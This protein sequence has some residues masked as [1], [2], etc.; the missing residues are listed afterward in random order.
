MRMTGAL[1]K[2]S[3][4]RRHASKTLQRSTGRRMRKSLIPT[5]RST[6]ITATVRCPSYRRGGPCARPRRRNAKNNLRRAAARAAPTAPSPTAGSGNSTSGATSLD[7]LQELF[8]VAGLRSVGVELQVFLEVALRFRLLL[9]LE[10]REASVEVP[11]GILGLD[12]DG[13]VE[14]LP[15]SRRVLLVEEH[16]PGVQVHTGVLDALGG[17]L[18]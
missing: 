14:L 10:G 16:D 12:L 11:V 9:Q 2:T 1:G 13:S 5:R 7:G 15:G 18:V 4:R 6:A 3:G 17:N 8:R